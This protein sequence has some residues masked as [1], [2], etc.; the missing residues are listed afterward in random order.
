MLSRLRAAQ[1]RFS[2]TFESGHQVLGFLEGEHF[3]N[4][5][6]IVFNLRSLRAICLSPEGQL[7]MSFDTVF[8]Q[9]HTAKPEIL[10]SGSHSEQGSFFSFNYR[11]LEASVY[12]A[13]TDTWITS[14]W[15]PSSWT[16]E[17][18]T[19]AIDRAIALSALSPHQAILMSA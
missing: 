16:V 9:F 13:V 17:T 4:S 12:D 5:P 3:R 6:S 11:L 8:G 18:L 2:Y 19:P 1:F 15:N 10:F 14:G 7:L